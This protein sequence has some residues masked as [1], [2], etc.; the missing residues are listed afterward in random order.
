[1]PAALCAQVREIDNDSCTYC[2]TPEALT[3]T[4]FEIDHII[5]ASQG[6]E[7][8]LDNLCLSCPSCNRHKGARQTA[9]DPETGEDVPLY[10]PRQQVWSKHFAWGDD[11]TRLEGL[12]SVV[13]PPIAFLNDRTSPPDPC[14]LSAAYWDTTHSIASSSNAVMRLW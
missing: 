12:T 8:M 9:P 5:P 6:G 14:Q 7:T 2:H 3:V 1:M 11:G 10:H 4:T 13:R